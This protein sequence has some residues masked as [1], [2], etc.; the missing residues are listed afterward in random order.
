MKKTALTVL[1][2]AITLGVLF[3]V[4]HDPQKRA[5]ML[6]AL[7]NA[8]AAWLFAGIAAYGVVELLAGVRWQLLLRVQGIGLPW[9]RLFRL[10]MIG[11]FFN[12][13]IPGGTG[14]DVVK[15]FYLL[16]ET[17]GQRPAALLSV[18][19]DRLIG[20]FGLIV[21]GGAVA[22]ARWDWL[23]ASPA[24]ARCVWI[25]LAVLGGSLA[26]VIVSLTLSSLG[27]VHR[28]PARMPGRDKLAELAVAYNLYGRAWRPSLAALGLS[29][30]VHA[31]VFLTFFCAAKALETPGTRIPSL[32][33][34]A[35]VMPV[36]NTITSLPISLGGVGVREGLFQIF[37]SELVGVSEA[38][39]VVIAFTGFLLTLFWGLVGGVFYVGYR[40]SE[41]RR[42]G[43]ISEEIAAFE[44]Q[45]AEG[46]LAD[47]KQR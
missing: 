12:F 9:P 4:F 2:L 3:L 28:L 7:Q 24:A 45:V 8:S 44:H 20:L 26:A 47:E 6:R 46:E 15:V 25:T 35:S 39:A 33:D 10:L 1:Q 23:T 36:V 37:L 13:F 30:L 32:L 43:E 38:V 29:L 17:P 5:D 21:I 19:I 22:I 16:K 31:G 14:G 11:V 27:L 34:L 42:L 18:L 41:H 40:P